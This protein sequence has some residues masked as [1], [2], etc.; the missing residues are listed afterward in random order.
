MDQPS[1]LSG[2]T[3]RLGAVPAVR[4]LL[5][6]GSFGRGDAD[7]FSDL[8]LIAVVGQEDQPEFLQDWRRLLGGVCPVV[9]WFGPPS[10]GTLCAVTRD[11]LRVDL[12]LRLP[13]QVRGLSRASHRVVLDP[14]GIAR[15]L[16]DRLPAPAPDASRL[17]RLISEFLRVFGLLPVVAGRGEWQTAALGAGLQRQALIDLMVMAQC[18]PDRRGALCLSRALPPPD[19][20][21]LAAIPF[22]QGARDDVLAAHRALAEA[23]LPRARALAARWGSD[24]PEAFEA[25][26]RTHVANAV[27]LELAAAGSAQ[28]HAD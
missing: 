19:M 17:A 23:F 5:L 10:G 20:A 13:G 25:A 11:W 2:L 6:G 14:D 22:P 27:G 15:D 26:T 1:L 12:T 3:E 18:D 4:A 9:H 7:R 16:P 28:E 21:V 8:D 24:W